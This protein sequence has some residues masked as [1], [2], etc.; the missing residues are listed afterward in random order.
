MIVRGAFAGVILAL[1]AG[2]AP[3]AAAPLERC[4][5]DKS[6]R[7]GT[8]QVPVHRERASGAEAEGAL[9]RLSAHRPLA[10]RAGADRDGRGRAGLRIHR[11]GLELPVHAAAAAR[12]RHDMIVIDNRGT[13]QLGRDRLSAPSGL[14]RGNYVREVGRCGRK[15]GKRADAYGS[16]AAADDLAAVLDRLKVPVVDIYGDSYG[17]Y[18]A[19]TFAVRHPTRVRAVVLDAAYAVTG[20]RSVGA[21]AERADPLRLARRLRA[22]GRLRERCRWR[23]WVRW[24]SDSSAGRW[25]AR[26]VTP[27]APFAG[28]ASTDGDR[29]D[30]RRRKHLLRDLPRPARGRTRP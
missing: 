16:G 7:C 23:S 9:S 25:W 22:L 12:A 21:R 26:R 17:T 28:S 10:P 15:L 29:P 13:G 27:T 2:V 19:Q 6:A 14:R 3:A 24:H 4:R 5:D 30:E 1:F 18:F 8:I 11:L 20:F